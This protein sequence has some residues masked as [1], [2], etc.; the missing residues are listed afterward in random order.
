MWYFT[1]SRKYRWLNQL[2]VACFIGL[3]IGPE[4]KTQINLVI[5]Q[6]LDTIQPIWPWVTDPNTGASE[7]RPS[8]VE[9]LVFVIVAV[10]SLVYF[11]FVFRPKTAAGR[12]VLIAGRLA[13]MVGFGAMFGNTVNT[14]L[15][16]LAP[17]IG[18]LWDQWLAKL[19][20]G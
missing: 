11:I 16:W 2:I 4:F 15:S 8:R 13:M 5:P 18:F 19:L 9:H 1:Y 6:I 20:A 3:M 17:R 10:L 14:R 7:F 12:G